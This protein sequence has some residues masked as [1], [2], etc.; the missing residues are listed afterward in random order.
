MWINRVT[1]GLSTAPRQFE[2][3]LHR[4]KS[5]SHGAILFCL[6]FFSSTTIATAQQITRTR[7]FTPTAD[8]Y[9]IELRGF[10]RLKV[11]GSVD[12]SDGVGEMYQFQVE[13]S[14][15]GDSNYRRD[16]D[17]PY[18]PQQHRFLKKTGTW[19][20]R[21]GDPVVRFQTDDV[22]SVIAPPAADVAI[23]V[24]AKE[25]DC[26]RGRECGRGSTGEWEV[27]FE[28]PTFLVPLSR[29][30]TVANTFQLHTIDDEWHLGP[31]RMS[32]R[33]VRSDG[34]ILKFDPDY[35]PS[36]C[37]RQP[38][39]KPFIS[40]MVYNSER[41]V[42]LKHD[43]NA[44]NSQKEIR[45]TGCGPNFFSPESKTFYL[46]NLSKNNSFFISDKPVTF[47]GGGGTCLFNDGRSFN[48]GRHTIMRATYRPCSI[49]NADSYL[50]QFGV[51]HRRSISSVETGNCLG[52]GVPNAPYLTFNDC[53]D[54]AFQRWRLILPYRLYAYWLDDPHFGYH[55][56]PSG[57]RRR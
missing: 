57:N 42:C 14:T 18:R 27:R 23:R 37:I 26:F 21:R 40:A 19:N 46:Q 56:I 8:D 53:R 16:I 28:V 39:A 15:S 22:L 38:S 51:K 43:V 41:E 4:H 24:E 29:Q 9:I 34:P 47:D 33:I 45:L 20:I 30:C 7:E 49:K 17:D 54:D 31:V 48:T 32:S 50:W 10:S 5:L 13:L 12:D 2:K 35:P 36:I 55:V 25:R 3:F 52:A 6:L 11:G 44:E 1:V